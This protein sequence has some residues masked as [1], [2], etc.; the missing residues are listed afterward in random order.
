MNELGAG[1]EVASTRRLPVGG[2][3]DQVPAALYALAHVMF[4]AVGVWLWA[5]A[6]QHGLAGSGALALYVVS[7]VGFLAY[8]GHAIT[9]KTAVL[10]EQI[11]VCAMLLLIV[12]SAT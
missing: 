10:V 6:A 1:R 12:L 5:R 4:L 9:M 11:A 3:L 2:A 8:F 7:Q